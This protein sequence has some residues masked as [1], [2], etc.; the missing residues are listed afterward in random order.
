LRN[1]LGFTEPVTSTLVGQVNQALSQMKEVKT[2]SEFISAV[3]SGL[4]SNCHEDKSQ[5]ISKVF[6]AFGEKNPF[7]GK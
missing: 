5:L 1:F 3:T 2:Q 7:S 4:T 6:E